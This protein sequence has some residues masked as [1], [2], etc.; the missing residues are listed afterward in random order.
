MISGPLVEQVLTEVDEEVV[1]NVRITGKDPISLLHQLIRSNS[2]WEIVFE[3]DD[4]ET[5]R[6]WTYADVICRISR[7]EQHGKTI[8]IDGLPV[9]SEEIEEALVNFICSHDHY[10]PTVLEDNALSL[11]LGE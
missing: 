3:G 8:I 11:I 1:F 9:T 4:P 6:E 7:A 10:L 2:D 5:I